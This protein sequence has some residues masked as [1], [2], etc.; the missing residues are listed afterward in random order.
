MHN[1]NRHAAYGPMSADA[2]ELEGV[3]T[4]LGTEASSV[5]DKH[6]IDRYCSEFYTNY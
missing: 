1:I 3:D 6:L 2:G 4:R 5:L